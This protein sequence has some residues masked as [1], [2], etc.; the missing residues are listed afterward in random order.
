ML[1]RKPGFT[2]A[3]VLALALGVG[4][5][6]AIFSV[7]NAVVLRPLPYPNADRLVMLWAENTV[8]GVVHS[9]LSPVNF[10]DYRRLKQVFE[11]ATAWW[12]PEINLT[13]EQ[14]EPIR[15]DAI[16]VAGNFLDVMGAAPLVGSGFPAD[17]GLFANERKVLISHRFWQTRYR[18][19]Q[20]VI[21]QTVN[22]NGL[23]NLIVGVMPPGFN[24]PGKTDVWQRLGWDMTLHSRNAH[25]MEAVG[26]L[27]P[28]VSLDQ[29]N[30]ELAALAGRLGEEFTASNKDWR[31]QAVGLQDEIVGDFSQAVVVLFCAVSLLLLLA[32][33]NVANLMLA[34]ATSRDRELAIRAAI[35]ASRGRLFRQFLTESLLLG[36]AGSVA[37]LFVALASL[38]ILRRT[39]VSIPRIES[40]Q[41]DALVLAFCLIMGLVTTVVFGIL[42]A[43]Q[44]ASVNLQ[45]TLVDGG[46][47][48]S[49]GARGV[50]RN[51]LVVAEVGLAVVLLA[52]AGLL[53]RS[54]LQL[55]N[56]DTGFEPTSVVSLSIQLPSA[57]YQDYQRVSR[58]YTDLLRQLQT[59]PGVTSAGA[60]GFLPFENGWR[61][62]FVVQGQPAVD[63]AEE[64]IAQY[65]TI[66]PGYFETLSVPLLKGRALDFR[67]DAQSVAV[68]VINQAMARRYWA[69][70]DDPIDDVFVARANGIGPLGRVLVN[71]YSYRI[72]G[73]VGDVKNSSLTQEA[74]PAVFFS[75]QQ[76][77]YRV[78]NLVIR[79]QGTAGQLV[80]AARAE[81]KKLDA[82]LALSNI[83]TLEEIV[84]A[85]VAQPRFVMLLMAGFAALALVLAAVGIYG[86]LS[87]AVGERRREIGIR[88]ALGARAT[89]VQRLVVGEAIRWTL[90]GMV[91]GLV[92][93]LAAGR[94]M[95]SLLY[96]VNS[97]DLV[98]LGGVVTVT[99]LVSLV[100]CYLPA[101]RA[102][103]IDPLIALRSE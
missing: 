6:T 91:L 67:D 57:T 31:A 76:F 82:Q 45:Q 1:L 14:D 24:F 103:S 47:G 38:Q 66:T 69:T 33:A 88:M 61:I 80:G 26:R 79:G 58:F 30:R 36:L 83:Q 100:A 87:Y 11:D 5:N 46:R 2:L 86:V 13:D 12:Y 41:I 40:I 95:S 28:G 9:Q 52:G 62:P 20:A 16:E 54:F 51:L 99:L 3:A 81:I 21:G 72:V 49:S 89:N 29:T 70:D 98:A 39:A 56:E 84:Q 78:M 27:A 75:H 42:P 94:L 63:A 18:G 68:V 101:R 50:A 74:E 43:L 92:G 22:L 25:F 32:C 60:T 71:T 102:S 34:R 23:P 97:T 55:L 4:A 59:Q 17:E 93:A 44:T 48:G 73:V 7:M 19:D 90:L 35:G 37:G 77:P 8:D 65:T 85:T 96:R 10:M 64:P 15:V 53:I